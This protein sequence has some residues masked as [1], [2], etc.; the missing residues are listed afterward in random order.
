V[1]EKKPLTLNLGKEQLDE[2]GNILNEEVKNKEPNNNHQQPPFYYNPNR[3]SQVQD[4][5][6]NIN[7]NAKDT[8]V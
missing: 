1:K 5:Q 2:K 7:P 3:S 4:H 8:H 6:S